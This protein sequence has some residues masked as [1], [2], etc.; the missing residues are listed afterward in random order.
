[1]AESL[2]KSLFETDE[3]NRKN[4]YKRLG[5][6]VRLPD[7][8]AELYELHRVAIAPQLQ[9][10]AAE[11]AAVLY[12]ACRKHLALGITSLLRCYSS[13][14]F[15]ETRAAIEAVGIADTIRRDEE[16]FRVFRQD[17]DEASRKVARKQFRPANI[18]VAKL[19]RLHKCY[20]KALIR[21]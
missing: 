9:D 1:M 14:A 12:A 21:R 7:D 6:V 5:Q 10:A 8:V 2:I 19:K 17:R 16:S 18:F 4:V 11:I 3:Q 15:R 20:D 13:Q